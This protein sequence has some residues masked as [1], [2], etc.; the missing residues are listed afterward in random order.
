[1]KE[2]CEMI[3]RQMSMQMT[4]NY[5]YMIDYVSGYR[6]THRVILFI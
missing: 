4:N 1:M 2:Q 6:K 5:I 3:N